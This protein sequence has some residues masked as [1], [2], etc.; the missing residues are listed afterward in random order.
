[1]FDLY[2]I[3]GAKTKYLVWKYSNSREDIKN[4]KKK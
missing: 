2:A 4:V 1:M 3:D